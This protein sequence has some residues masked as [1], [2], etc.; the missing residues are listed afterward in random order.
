[1]FKWDGD[2]PTPVRDGVSVDY[3]PAPAPESLAHEA[4]IPGHY[5]PPVEF[6]LPPDLR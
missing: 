3:R 4:R 1:M 6:H 2:K 5:A